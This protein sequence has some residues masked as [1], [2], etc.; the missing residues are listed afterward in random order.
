MFHVSLYILC[1]SFSVPHSPSSQFSF[2]LIFTSSSSIQY[3]TQH[4]T[5]R[6]QALFVVFMYV[7]LSLSPPLTSHL[8]VSAAC[9]L[10]V[11]PSLYSLVCVFILYPED[12]KCSTCTICPIDGLPSS[13]PIGLYYICTELKR[14]PSTNHFKAK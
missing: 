3:H 5:E 14:G 13:W 6:Q 4:H 2:R 7:P 1:S 12:W 9:S 11:V 10:F 8:L